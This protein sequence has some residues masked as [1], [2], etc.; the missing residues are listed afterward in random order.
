M[1]LPYHLHRLQLGLTV[2]VVAGCGGGDLTVPPSTGTLE[3]TI[4]TSG[5]EQDADGYSV[6]ID[7]GTA[8]A[9]GAAATLT[10]SDV[11]P[12]NHT[13]RLGEVAANCTVGG[14]NPRTTIVTAGQTAAVS[15]AV[16][17]SAT[18]SIKVTTVTTGSLLDPDGYTVSVDGGAPQPIGINAELAM[19]GLAA[20]DHSVALAGLGTNCTASDGNPRTVT[21]PAGVE[22]PLR[23][24]VS[25]PWTAFLWQDMRGD[26]GSSEYALVDVWG[27]SA[28]DVYAVGLLNSEDTTESAVFHYDGHAWSKH[29][30]ENVGVKGVWASAPNDVFRVGARWFPEGGYDEA[31]FHFDGSTWSP[32]T[33]IGLG[34]RG[35]SPIWVFY[36]SVWGTSATDVFAVGSYRQDG[37]DYALIAHYDGVRWS[38]LTLPKEKDRILLG[39]S[40]TSSQDV[41]AVGYHFLADGITNGGFIVHFDGSQWTEVLT[42]SEPGVVFDVWSIS[43]SDVYAVGYHEILHYDGHSWS[44]TPTT[45]TLQG[46]WAAS[47]TDVYA[48]G[49][50]VNWV[51]LHYDGQTW[52]KISGGGS[53]V[54]GSSSTN[55]FVVG[56]GGTLLH[57]AR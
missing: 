41:Y 27:T 25:C 43:P 55:V 53:Q 17:C 18:S 4:A 6:Q 9:I 7:A 46:V 2:A 1:L 5:A 48:V 14:D 21:V 13:V 51:M 33:G 35:A 38:K 11:T 28:T 16:M 20:G 36:Q 54:W 29:T 10:T 19:P 26:A 42:E 12:G 44:R 47:S 37:T 39:I 15:F 31:I 3:I 8:R 40:G 22:A 52:T 45:E 34:R 57:G 24:T 30:E 50:I 56:G 32:M 23:F 49:G